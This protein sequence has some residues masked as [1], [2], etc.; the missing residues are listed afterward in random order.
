MK[1]WK[2]NL[3]QAIVDEFKAGAE[4]N[5]PPVGMTDRAVK[6]SDVAQKCGYAHIDRQDIADIVKQ[7]SKLAPELHAVRV[8]SNPAKIDASESCWATA[9]ITDLNFDA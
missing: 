7:V 9:Y 4:I 6:F 3:A 5:F 8:V 1:E 2:M